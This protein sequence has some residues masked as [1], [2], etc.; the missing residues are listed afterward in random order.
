MKT[1]ELIKAHKKA[2]KTLKQIKRARQNRNTLIDNVKV[3]ESKFPDL[4]PE[5]I[6]QIKEL[7]KYIIRLENVYFDLSVKIQEVQNGK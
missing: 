1:K 7:N 5:Y 6:E 3:C 4:R 2:L